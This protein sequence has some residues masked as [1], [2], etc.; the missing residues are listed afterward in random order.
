VDGL[1][2]VKQFKN[3]KVKKFCKS[4][5]VPGL[6]VILIAKIAENRLENAHRK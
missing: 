5:P 2:L 3:K 6:W 1:G 4:N